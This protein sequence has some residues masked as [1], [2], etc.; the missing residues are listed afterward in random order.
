MKKLKTKSGIFFF[1]VFLLMIPKAYATPVNTTVFLNIAQISPIYNMSV[2]EGDTVLWSFSTYNSSFNVMA[3]GGGVGTMVSSGKTS[4]SG[5]IVAVA[6]GNIAFTFMNSGLS[7]GY[8]DIAISIK[9]EN[10]IGAYTYI[11]FIIISFTIIAL[12]SIKKKSIRIR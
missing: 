5:S 12:I 1:L 7:S 2:S 11:S 6:T 9:V 10:S 4:D 3:V 8:I